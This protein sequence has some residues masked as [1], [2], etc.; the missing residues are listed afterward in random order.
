MTC[1]GLSLSC[2]QTAPACAQELP[3]T[4][5]SRVTLPC[6]CPLS[7]ELDLVPPL[8][9]EKGSFITPKAQ[10]VGILQIPFLKVSPVEEVGTEQ[11]VCLGLLLFSSFILP[12]LEI[13]PRFFSHLHATSGP[14]C[15]EQSSMVWVKFLPPLAKSERFLGAC[16]A[17]KDPLFQ[18][19]ACAL[20]PATGV[21]L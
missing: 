10:I 8:A 5:R 6:C 1:A 19:T 13:L 3:N 7:G 15:R 18:H 12:G 17:G 21:S 14:C 2:P 4:Q 16:G 20:P 9:W 11:G